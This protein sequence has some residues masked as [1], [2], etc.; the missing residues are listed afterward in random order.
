MKIYSTLSRKKETFKPVK[1]GCVGIYVCGPTVYDVGHLGHARSVVSFDIIRRYFAY[2]GYKVTFVSNITDVDDKIIKRSALLGISE[3]ELAEKVIPEYEKDY[4]LLGVIPPDVSPRATQYI[5]KMVELIEK[6]IENGFAY[7]TDDGVYFDVSKYKA[8]GELSHQKLDELQ[9]G[10]R[11]A[12]DEKKKNPADF[13][14]WKKEKQGEPAWDGPTRMRGRPGWH[15]EC[16]AMSLDLLGRPFDIH[17]GGIDLQFPHHEGERAQNEAVTGHVCVKYW[18]HNGHIRVNSEKMSKSLGNFFT[19]KEILAKYNPV[20]VRYFLLSTHYR[21]PIEFSN[22]LLEQAKNSLERLHDFMRR[23]N[24]F[25]TDKEGKISISKILKNVE[26]KFEE[27]LDNDF[28]IAEALAAIFELVKEVNALLDANK[29]NSSDVKTTIELMSKFDSVLAV[30]KVKD[31]VN[32]EV[33]ALIGE[34]STARKNKDFKRADEIR[35]ILLK[36]GVE[37]EDTKDGTV[38]KKM[39]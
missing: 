33:E 32:A 34:R 36:K 22:D 23:L 37:L 12:V 11:V 15:I 13:A 30:L 28:E 14:L 6:L 4:G 21:M 10:A 7:S 24:N 16:S 35:Q 20:V 19:I 1:K 17:G 2:K 5:P 3:S 31:N 39:L 38:W 26:K 29:L 8:Y 18:L 27:A 25:P 9:A